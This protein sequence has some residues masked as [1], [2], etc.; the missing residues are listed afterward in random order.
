MNQHHAV[1][2]SLI[3]SLVTI[4]AAPSL[5][6]EVVE[7]RSR[8][9]RGVVNNAQVFSPDR[10][11]A[12]YILGRTVA[13]RNSSFGINYR[14]TAGSQSQMR[15]DTKTNSAGTTTANASSV[16]AIEGDQVNPVT[17]FHNYRA[18]ANARVNAT[19]PGAPAMGARGR[20]SDP[21][22]FDLDGLA[23]EPVLTVQVTFAQGTGVYS[24]TE[25]G[26]ASLY[27]DG[28]T[29][30]I[31]G[32]IWS[33]SAWADG[34]STQL[35]VFLN[36]HQAVSFSMTASEL[37]MGLSSA[38]FFSESGLADDLVFQFSIDTSQFS[39]T[40]DEWL[41]S[42]DRAQAAFVPAPGAAGLLAAAGVMAVR[43]RRQ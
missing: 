20:V 36:A 11:Q 3:L 15:T 18:E 28:T 23:I 33:L 32:P 24:S 5:A 1:R 29:S 27:S 41:G 22:Y 6:A 8:V 43:R 14:Y 13:G 26:A 34:L 10:P 4:S 39:L 40:A 9:G 17:G 42:L 16:M 25:Q 19:D 38:G 37:A 30:L 2:G 35:D 12:N 21:Q 7:A 31:A